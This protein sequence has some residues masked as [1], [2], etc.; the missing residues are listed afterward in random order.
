MPDN[1]PANEFLNLE[2][3]KMSTSRKWSVEM[4]DYFNAF[5]GK[6]DVLR[7]VLTA[8]APETKDADF[9]WKDFQT[10]NNSELVSILGNFINRVAVLTHKFYE[11]KVPAN[12]APTEKETDL[13]AEIKRCQTAIAE[14]I[15]H[16]KFREALAE[17]MNLARLGNKYLA[18]TEPWKLIKT[19]EKRV[20]TIMNIAL[21]ITCN[22]AIVCE[23]FIPFTSNK[24]FTML[25][26]NFF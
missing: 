9:S 13:I 22:L 19:D 25:N 24:L 15:E 6:E 17:M 3:D 23:P 16:F 10:R 12:V 26:F 20:Q 5:P 11:G 14:N 7:Y 18:E 4:E 21:Q 2:G 1:V 8:I